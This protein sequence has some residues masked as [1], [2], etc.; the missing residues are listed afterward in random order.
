MYCV[1]VYLCLEAFSRRRTNKHTY[2]HA[3]AI[4]RV[5]EKSRI[6]KP[7][8]FFSFFLFFIYS[9][10][11]FF[12]P[13]WF[14]LSISIRLIADWQQ[15]ASADRVVDVNWFV[16]QTPVGYTPVRCSISHPF[17]VIYFLSSF[18][19]FFS[20]EEPPS[21]SL[22]VLDASSSLHRFCSYIW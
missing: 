5:S 21:F 18:F 16:S 19:H 1:C 13:S 20:E 17:S 22:S 8:G 9:L 7:W 4:G 10:T 3:H 12:P 2:R 14:V 11:Y 6:Y 15:R